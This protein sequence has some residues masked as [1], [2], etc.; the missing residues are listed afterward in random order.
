M[1]NE[2]DD[3]NTLFTICLHHGD[4]KKLFMVDSQKA[5]TEVQTKITKM[6]PTLSE[7]ATTGWHCEFDNG[8]WIEDDADW[9]VVRLLFREQL[10]V[11]KNRK[12]EMFVVVG[13]ELIGDGLH[14]HDPPSVANGGG[15]GGEPKRKRFKAL[16]MPPPTM[17]HCESNLN[18]RS[19]QSRTGITGENERHELW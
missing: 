12:F 15:G 13:N 19:E 1:S 5:W 6:F 10:K 14:A 3:D 18:M 2:K 4:R 9:Q 11:D 8:T 17:Y 7:C 16:P